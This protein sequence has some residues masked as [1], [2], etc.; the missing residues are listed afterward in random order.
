MP[1][2]NT[3]TVVDREAAA[4]RKA[5]RLARARRKTRAAL[6][7]EADVL[8]GA[9]TND[10]HMDV[11]D[12]VSG[13]TSGDAEP[14]VEQHLSGEETQDTPPDAP[15]VA[16]EEVPQT[17]PM[18]SEAEGT[19][20]DQPVTADTQTSDVQTP[21]PHVPSEADQTEPETTKEAVGQTRADIVAARNARNPSQPARP[22]GRAARAARTAPPM[23]RVAEG[24]RFKLRHFM[25][26][27]SFLALVIV[28]SA[29]TYWYLY[30]RAADQFVSSVGFSVRKEEVGSAVEVLGS[31]SNISSGSS[32]DTDILYEFI[33]SQEQVVLVN[34]RLDL[35]AI[36][37]K[38]K[39]DPLFALPPNSSLEELVEYWNR[40]VK[41]FYNGSNG[42]IQIRVHAFDPV[43]ARDIAEAIFDESSLMI[44]KLSM[45]ARSDATRYASEELD[46]AVERL[47]QARQAITTFRNETQI[48][49]P[50]ADLQGQMGLINTLQQQLA[51]ALIDQDL[52][53]QT[54]QPNDPRNAQ[55]QRKV[56]V[57]R[58]RIASEREKFSS[59]DNEET[60]AY[61]SLIARYEGLSVELEFAE[62]FYL[63]AL[64]TYDSARAEA[65]RTSRYLA[66]YVEP[67]LAETAQYPQ[68]LIILGLVA[69][70]AFLIWSIV[71]M[72]GYS[73]RSR[74]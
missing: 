13:L 15:W 16:I 40:M 30:E 22:Q 68:R 72:V 37:S 62:Q 33:Q 4:K 2:K 3:R 59:S 18:S 51:E 63:S 57:I 11:P 46:L 55:A 25:V 32:S 24:A 21:R 7:S 58:N 43:D 44:N 66:A 6:A 34:N 65:Q 52:L 54:T 42:L 71:I 8:A 14:D 31:I 1:R 17:E 69:F 47:K 23:P 38:P 41:I 64:Q 60:A 19:E 5:R 27:F 70:F 67:T 36:Y 50:K 73:V 61:S 56:E 26:V 53:L 48:V 10:L 35:R 9:N 39:N 45:I 12:E 20:L 28:P 74:R 29:G 49:D